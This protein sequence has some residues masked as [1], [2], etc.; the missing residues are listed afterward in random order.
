MCS[1]SQRVIRAC[2]E[3]GGA[4]PVAQGF[5]GPHD[6]ASRFRAKVGQVAAR[7]DVRSTDVG[8]GAGIGDFI[9]TNL[10]FETHYVDGNSGVRDGSG[11]NGHIPK[12]CEE[13]RFFL[14]R[15]DHS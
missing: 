2:A 12:R 14:M 9:R 3:F 1:T 10:L 4:P 7:V 13:S 8:D 15:A 6:A 11:V 5:D